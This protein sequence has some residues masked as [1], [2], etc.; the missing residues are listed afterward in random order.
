MA[1]DTPG[2]H[3][4]H[5]DYAKR[6]VGLRRWHPDRPPGESTGNVTDARGDE[7]LYKPLELGVAWCSVREVLAGEDKPFDLVY[8]AGE[9]GI[10]AGSTVKFWMAGQGSLGTAPQVG[11]PSQPGYIEVIAPQSVQLETLCDR[12]RVISLVDGENPDRPP[13]PDDL[14]VGPVTIGFRLLSG[15]LRKGDRVT[16]RVGRSAGFR[17]KKL[18]GRKEFKV[19]IEEAAA[20]PRR[21]LPEPVIV[22]IL[23]LEPESLEVLLPPTFREGETLDGSVTIRDR[24]DN[25]VPLNCAVNAGDQPAFLSEGRGVF[26]LHARGGAMRVDAC[27]EAPLLKTKSNWSVPVGDDGLKL[28][29]GDMHTHDFNSTAEAYT[30]DVYRWARDDKKLDFLSVPI[31]VHR[32]IDNEKWFLAKH[33]NECFLDEGKFVTFLAFEWQHSH[34]GDKVIHYLG[35]DAPYLPVDD[36][37]YDH[38]AAL[39]DA[40][41][42]TDAF[43]ISHHPGYDLDLHVPGTDWD[44]VVDDVDR[45]LELWSMH[46]SSEGYDTGDRPLVSPRRAEGTYEGLRRGLRCGFV[47]G[48]DTHTGRPGGS[49]EDAR[50]YWGGMCAVWADANTRRSLFAAFKARRTYALTGARIVLRFTV[51]GAPMGAEVPMSPE[52]LLRASVWAPANVSSVQFLRNT[53]VCYD[54]QPGKEVCEVEFLDKHDTDAPA[55]YHCRVTLEDGH[56]AVCSPVWVG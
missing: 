20:L 18:A 39:Y 37:R 55:F 14:I 54:T 1:K 30:A 15:V 36:P 28:F 12:V 17:W 21:R 53:E 34:Y 47:A 50:P 29:F 25:R 2:Y 6:V 44:A 46:G 42:K 48:S 32:Y 52:A 3:K 51:N 7:S 16:F 43:I 40:L 5:V 11:D 13:Q 26:Q 33:M 8:E 41:R 35:G 24:Y 19:I 22:M 45:L 10:D 9:R 56:L 23:P 27:R 31:Q 38:P 4:D 49:A